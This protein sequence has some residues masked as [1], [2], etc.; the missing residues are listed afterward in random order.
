MYWVLC[1]DCFQITPD[2]V[3]TMSKSDWQKVG[4]DLNSRKG[5]LVR[6]L[7]TNR[8]IPG[9]IYEGNKP[10][11]HIKKEAIEELLILRLPLKE[12]AAR[13]GVSTKTLSR[14]MS[15]YGIG[16]HT[17]IS[18]ADLQD[19]I[20]VVLDQHPNTGESMLQGHLAYR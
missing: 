1:C 3:G 14:R 2:L 18:Q 11:Y 17:D 15:E 16:K 13:L 12:I 5:M 7:S 6:Q 9:L 20:K 8:V 19:Q 4:M 10:K